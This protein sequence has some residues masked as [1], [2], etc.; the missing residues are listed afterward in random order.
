MAAVTGLSWRIFCCVLGHDM[1]ASHHLIVILVLLAL[2]A[3]KNNDDTPG[4]EIVCLGELYVNENIGD[5]IFPGTRVAPYKTITTAL[6]FAVAGQTVCVAPGIYDTSLMEAFPVVVPQGVRLIG[7][8]A[9]KGIGSTATLISGGGNP[10]GFAPNTIG[11]AVVLSANATL[12][13][14]SITVPVSDHIGIG[15]IGVVSDGGDGIL[16]TA[17]TIHDISFDDNTWSGG[18]GIYAAAGSLTVSKNDIYNIQDGIAL[19]A[20]TATLT[21]RGNRI[22]EC[23]D[24][25]VYVN[26]TPSVDLGTATDP[27]NNTLQNSVA[28]VT[29]DKAVGLFNCS[30][31][32]INAVGNT[33][34]ATTRAPGGV[35][36]SQTIIDGGDFPNI[37]QSTAVECGGSFGK[38]VL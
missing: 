8:V 36:P 23:S 19:V 35:Y 14:F 33:W 5:D 6:T 22:T 31:V 17:N 27:G 30:G 13:G 3:C 2:T 9:N 25:C 15:G 21:A 24:N 38:V 37:L 7:D 1:K 10:P 12:S 29:Q 32:T 26:G 20:S 34:N 4:K 16:I 11:A 28:R 18:G